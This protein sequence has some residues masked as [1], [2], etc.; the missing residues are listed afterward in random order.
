[1]ARVGSRGTDKVTWD[2]CKENRAGRGFLE[3][4]MRYVSA[5]EMELGQSGVGAEAAGEEGK[6]REQLMGSPHGQAVAGSSPG[7]APGGGG[8]PAASSGHVG[9]G[10]PHSSTATGSPGL[11]AHIGPCGYTCGAGAHGVTL[12]VSGSPGDWWQEGWE[13]GPARVRGGGDGGGKGTV[14]ERK[15]PSR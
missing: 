5:K 7:P 4:G 8:G 1:M 9:S 6:D 3:G 14:L 10:C 13:D 15:G 2:T 11:P 12:R